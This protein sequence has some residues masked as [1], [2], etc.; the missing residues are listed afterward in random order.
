MNMKEYKKAKS[1]QVPSN[2]IECGAGISSK[3]TD[4]LGMEYD[5]KHCNVCKNERKI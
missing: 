3:K 4:V 1:K 5:N 2:C